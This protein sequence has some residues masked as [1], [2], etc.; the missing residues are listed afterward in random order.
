MLLNADWMRC[1]SFFSC[2][3]RYSDL[4]VHR[5][6]VRVLGLGDGGSEDRDLLRLSETGDH[7]S[8]TERRSAS[9]ERDAQD[10]FLASFLASHIGASFRGRV[11]GVTRFGLFVRLDDTGADGLVPM[12]TLPDDY[13]EHDVNAHALIGRR[14]GRT[15]RL[16]DTV[17]VRLDQADPLTGAM[18][19]ALLANEP[20]PPISVAGAPRRGGK[21]G[22][23]NKTVGRHHGKAATGGAKRGKR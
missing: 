3:M 1:P 4:V 10:R 14:W 8:M 17:T 22:G 12:R 2:D 20:G 13:Y 9:A 11:C 7:L 19:L 23:G 5:V 16:G 18:V 15:Y 21:G 6:L